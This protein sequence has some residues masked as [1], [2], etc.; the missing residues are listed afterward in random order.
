MMED[1]LLSIER[2]EKNLQDRLAE[3]EE[4]RS[5]LNRL[6][7]EVME[8]AGET[9]YHL[10]QILAADLTAYDALAANDIIGSVRRYTRDID[11]YFEER[12]ELM[13]AQE[14]A[15]IDELEVIRRQKSMEINRLEE[16][17]RKERLDG[18]Y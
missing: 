13:R 11:A 8:S 14:D 5:A 18:Q 9:M 15:T 12:K 6:E 17:Q 3:L 2:Q 4:V 1:T 10:S 7:E 16:A